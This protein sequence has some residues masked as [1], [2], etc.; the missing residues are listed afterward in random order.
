MSDT[1][2]LR[3]QVARAIYSAARYDDMSGPFGFGWGHRWV[4]TEVLSNEALDEA[5]QQCIDLADA[6][7]AVADPLIRADE[8]RKVIEELANSA[9]WLRAQK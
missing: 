4:A 8:R 5:E 6:A 2:D 1:N 3:E 7:I 9:D